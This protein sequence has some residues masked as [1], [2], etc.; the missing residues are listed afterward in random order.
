MQKKIIALAVAGLVSGVALAQSNVTIYGVVDQSYLY[1]KSNSGLAAG[2]DYKFSGMRDGND[3]GLQ[4]TR[5]GFKGEEALGNGLKAI[6]NLELRLWANDGVQTNQMR[7]SFVGLNSATLGTLTLGRQYSAA[8]D[9]V[10]N[11]SSN[12]YTTINPGNVFQGVGGQQIVS[13]GGNAR[14]SNMIKYVSPTF[15]GFTGR[16][17]YSF[18]DTLGSSSTAYQ[19]GADTDDNTRWALSADYTNGPLNVDVIYART[20]SARVSSA[21]SATAAAGWGGTPVA[22]LGTEGND[23]NEWYVGGAYDFKVVKLFGSYQSL[24]N[25]NS[26]AIA[27]TGSKL[28]QVGLSVPVGKAGKVM[29]EYADIKF[30]QD[31]NVDVLQQNGKNKGWGLGYQHDLS[32]RTAV[33]AFVSSL[34]YGDRTA[35]INGVTALGA[36][37]AQGGIATAAQGERQTNFNMGLRHAF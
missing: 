33:Y 30:K 4:G 22:I 25:G 14:Q 37:A 35:T 7:Q 23:I 24:K 9:L 6:F 17:N 8:G 20:S 28:W 31:N 32:K 13:A 3:N 21:I 12:G 16:A 10:G 1:S 2:G 26:N 18:S 19:V 36:A 34:D 15:S 29:L 5:L 27:V 11:N